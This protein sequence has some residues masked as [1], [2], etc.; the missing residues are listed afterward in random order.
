MASPRSRERHPFLAPFER[1]RGADR[2]NQ[3]PPHLQI[4]AL[5]ALAG[6]RDDATLFLLGWLQSVSPRTTKA[7]TTTISSL[8]IGG[9]VKGIVHVIR[10]TYCYVD[11]CIPAAARSTAI[12]SLLAA[13][14]VHQLRSPPKPATRRQAFSSE[15]RELSS[16]MLCGDLLRCAQSEEMVWTHATFERIR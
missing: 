13:M 2:D 14:S 5:Q 16:W 12:Q 3:P 11:G 9:H 6:S 4:V 1:H 15:L 8:P 7:W 10:S